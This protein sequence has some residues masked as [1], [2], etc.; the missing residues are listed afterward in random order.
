M[1]LYSDSVP[2]MADDLRL[3]ESDDLNSKYQKALDNKNII[4]MKSMSLT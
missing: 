3:A 4:L 1:R 2:L